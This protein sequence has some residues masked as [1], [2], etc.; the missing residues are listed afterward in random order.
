MLTVA[1]N[2]H[3]LFVNRI[4]SAVRG[5]TKIDN[6]S[7]PDHHNCR[8]GKWYDTE[9]TALCGN[10]PSF[11]AITPP[12]ERIHALSKDA[13]VAVNSGQQQLADKLMNEIEQVSRS[14]MDTLE[15]TRREY[16]AHK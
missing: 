12:H 6:S 15:N 1:A 8:F 14:I 13:I 9:G 3:R 16:A 4:R 7:L 10:L 11:R 5:E 2:D